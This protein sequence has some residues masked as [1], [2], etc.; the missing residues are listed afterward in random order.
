MFFVNVSGIGTAK[1]GFGQT[2]EVQENALFPRLGPNRSMGCLILAIR[3][4]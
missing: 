3:E 2:L 1:R 4:L